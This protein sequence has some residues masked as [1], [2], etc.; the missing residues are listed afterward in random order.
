M[1][2]CIGGLRASVGNLNLEKGYWYTN[3]LVWTNGKP[4]MI[5][6]DN[7]IDINITKRYGEQVTTEKLNP[8]QSKRTMGVWKNYTRRYK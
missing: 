4:S 5:S 2:D 1:Y 8:H 3:L 7:A 6:S